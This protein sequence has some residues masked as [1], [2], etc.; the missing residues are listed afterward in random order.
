MFAAFI[1]SRHAP[2]LF[3]GIRGE[4]LSAEL[5]NDVSMYW[6]I[7]LL[8]LA[9]VVPATI[10]VAVA[11]L[12]DLDWGRKALFAVLGWFA[13][14]PASIAAMSVVMVVRNDPNASVGQAIVLTIAALVFTGLALVPFR[15]LFT[16]SGDRTEVTE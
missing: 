12:R 2:A 8:D 1:V 15:R 6:S 11:L 14:V 3:A 7:L 16:W 9:I 13:L 10:A 5:R 4:P